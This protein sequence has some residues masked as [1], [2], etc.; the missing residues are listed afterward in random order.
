MDDQ[1]SYVL[2]EIV[3][4]KNEFNYINYYYQN[5]LIETDGEVYTLK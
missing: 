4:T 2:V 3:Y 1:T 5:M